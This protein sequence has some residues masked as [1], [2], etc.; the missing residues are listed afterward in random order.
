LIEIIESFLVPLYWYL[1][2]MAIMKMKISLIR[3]F[4][5]I[6]GL[7]FLSFTFEVV[8]QQADKPSPGLP[9]NIKK[10][11]TNS[12]MPCHTSKGGI[13]PQSRLNFTN[14][15]QYSIEKQKDKAEK[16]YSVLQKAKMPPKDAR[17]TNPDIIPTNEQVELIKSWADSLN[18]S[19]EK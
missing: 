18:A 19:G 1:L 13:L 5:L 7:T 11:V 17:E 4:L 16:I 10:I 15:T 12:C 9:D 2:K 14:W 3:A 6:T 8:G